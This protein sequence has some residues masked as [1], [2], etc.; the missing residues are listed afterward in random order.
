MKIIDIRT[1]RLGQSP[2]IRVVTDEGLDGLA[3]IEYSKPYVTQTLGL[4]RELL[5]GEDPT[6]VERCMMRIRRLGGYKPWGAVV[7][8]IE[9]ALWDI[10]ARALDVPIHRLLGGKTRDRLRVYNGGVR[11]PLGDHSPQ[12]YAD[13]MQHM[14]DSPHGFSLFKEGVGLH[15]FMAQHVPDFLYAGD[16]RTGPLHPNRGP[17][18]PGAISHIVDCVAAMKDVLGPRRRLA[19]DMGPGWTVSDAITILTK[20][21]PYDL[22]W[23][24]DLLTGDFVPWVDV[25][26]Y[27]EITQATRVPTHTGEQVYLRHGFRELIETNAVRVIGPDPGD[28]GGLA[29]L[30]WIAEYAEM[31]GVQ[32]APHGVS[33]GL[34]GLAAL[35]QVS[36]TLPDNLIAF[37]YP[38]AQDPW[39]NEIVHGLPPVHDGF[40]AVGEAPGLGVELDRDAARPRLEP[41]AE[42][43][44]DWPARKDLT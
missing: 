10:N 42:D 5:L 32:I 22:A 8:A 38:L 40:V 2:I 26:G 3:E 43:F 31:H 44:F 9:I 17:L 18:T 24:E 7:S 34:L 6:Q 21:E 16:L 23:A 39:W 19:L 37:E 4:Y 1:A 41:G 13:S 11:V 12:A 15:G 28:V 20:L 29:E 36:A 30:K 25:P 14:V 33:S 35:I 27:R